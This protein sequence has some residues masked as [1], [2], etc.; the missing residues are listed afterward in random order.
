MCSSICSWSLCKS[1]IVSPVATFC[2]WRYIVYFLDGNWEFVEFSLFRPE[3]SANSLNLKETLCFHGALNILD[4]TDHFLNFRKSFEPKKI[5]NEKW[6]F[7]VGKTFRPYMDI[8]SWSLLVENTFTESLIRVLIIWRF[9][10]ILIYT[11]LIYN[12]L[13]CK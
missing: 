6:H 12:L 9:E 13:W 11:T 1:S 3:N 8:C 7:E 10:Q 4:Y 5:G 2:I